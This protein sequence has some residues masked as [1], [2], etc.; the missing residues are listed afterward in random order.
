[1]VSGLQVSSAVRAGCCVLTVAG[2]VDLV[3]SRV[4]EVALLR[5]TGVGMPLV[6]DLGGVEFMDSAGFYVVVRTN[7]EF[8]KTGQRLIVVPS[9]VVMGLIEVAGVRHVLALRESVD[10]ALTALGASTAD[11]AEPQASGTSGP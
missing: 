2:E 7:H 4:L 9:H 1:M 6:L 3:R 5:H 10:E 11:T 8:R